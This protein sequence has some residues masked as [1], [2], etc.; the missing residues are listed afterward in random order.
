MFYSLWNRTKSICYYHHP[1]LIVNRHFLYP[2]VRNTFTAVIN[3]I[4][5][6]VLADFIG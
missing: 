4:L 5:Q 2:I 6:E 3:L 1:G